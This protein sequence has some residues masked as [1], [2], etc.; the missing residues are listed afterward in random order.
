MQHLVGFFFFFFISSSAGVASAQSSF[1]IDVLN[2][3]KGNHV[4]ALF[5]SFLASEFFAIAFH[6]AI[7]PCSVIS[8]MSLLGAVGVGGLCGGLAA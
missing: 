7:T 2:A 1:N 4:C 6:S 3:T 8:P 5:F